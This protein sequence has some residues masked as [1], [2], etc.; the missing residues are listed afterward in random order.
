MTICN[1]MLDIHKQ[2]RKNKRK[3]TKERRKNLLFKASFVVE[4]GNLWVKS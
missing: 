2:Q 4:A 1:L 3:E